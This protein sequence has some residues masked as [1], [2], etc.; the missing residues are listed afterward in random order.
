MNIP[1]R[2]AVANTPTPIQKLDKL[3]QLL[4]KNIYIKRDDFTGNEWSGNKIRK[5]EYAMHEAIQQ[6]ASVIITCGGLQSNHA[7]ATTAVANHLGLKTHLVLRGNK[8]DHPQGNLLLN[9]I[10][11]A[12][13]SYLEP[14][15]FNTEYL[16]FM[17]KLQS[18]YKQKDITAYIIPMG[19]SNGIGTFGYYNCFQEIKMQEE[20]LSIQFDTL[21]TAVG[22][23]G[24]YGGLFL[25]N[26]LDHSAKKIIGFNISSTP[27]YFKSEISKIVRESLSIMNYEAPFSEDEIH[28]IGD[29]EGIG[30]ALAQPSELEFIKRIAVLEGLILDP[31]YTGK[32]FRGLYTELQK[33]TFEDSQNIL[34]IHTGGLTGL[35]SFNTQFNF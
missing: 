4:N 30:Y 17:E 21:V 11:G 20:A 28:I 10:M 2:I 29:Y 31:V 34:F 26:L 1:S 16:S 23:G 13:I 22:S 3:S 14:E 33:G 15:R 12:Q 7:R 9:E 19:A 18:E 27:D 35:Y 24:T 6:G 25:G 8:Q 32:A 5:L